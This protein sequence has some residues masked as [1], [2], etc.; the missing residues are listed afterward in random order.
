MVSLDPEMSKSAAVQR[1]TFQWH[2]DGTMVEYPH[3]ITLLSCLEP[4]NDGRGD[5]EFANTYAAYEALRT[6]KRPS[7]RVS[8]FVT[9]T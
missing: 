9:A 7:S 1:G 4:A 6:V 2:I 5:T 8:R 3:Q